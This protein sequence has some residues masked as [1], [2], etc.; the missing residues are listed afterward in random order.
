VGCSGAGGIG[1]EA[2]LRV[3]DRFY[4]KGSGKEGA[5]LDGVR[6]RVRVRA[7]VVG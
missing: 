5:Y 4:L 1:R 6:N 7:N 2:A 3:C